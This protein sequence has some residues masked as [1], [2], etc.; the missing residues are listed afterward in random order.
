MGYAGWLRNMVRDQA[1]PFH[2]ELYD[3]GQ[4]A[5]EPVTRIA[6]AVDRINQLERNR[7]AFS[8]KFLFL[9]TDQLTTDTQRAELAHRRAAENKIVVIWQEPTHEAFLLR[10]LPRCLTLRPA[11]KQ[12]ADAELSKKWV[13][14]KK[15]LDAELIEKRI[16]IEGALRVS[17]HLPELQDLLG[18]IGLLAK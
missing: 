1:L 17:T 10:H 12:I 7:L 6:M 18:A 16:D 9:D 15:P 14:Y 11:N 13:G 5:G 3:L 4:G 2:I 8:R